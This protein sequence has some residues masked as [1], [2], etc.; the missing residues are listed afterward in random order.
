MRE[1]KEETVKIL[2]HISF[3][4]T[5]YCGYQIQKNKPTVQGTLCE[6]ASRVFGQPCDI[7]GCSRTDSGVHANEFCATVTFKG[8]DS[9][10]TSIPIERIPIAFSTVLPSDISVFC[11]E[12]VS[13]AFHPRYDVL[14]KEYEYKIYSGA[15]LDPFLSGRCW[16]YPRE[17]DENALLQMKMAAK[18]FIGKNDFASYMASGSDIKDTTRTIVSASV[19]RDGDLIVFSVSADGFLYNMVRI[20]TGTL[21]SV[22]EGKLRPEDIPEVT[23]SLDRRRA[24]VTAPAE[25][26]YLCRVVYREGSKQ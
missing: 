24:G 17:I 13:G 20:L 26:L 5:N 19:R 3:L 10:S 22:A 9:I 15:L 1:R 25:G 14:Y 4:G 7:T 12:W 21:I 6:A 16:H 11:A 18:L 8:K 2:L 23:A